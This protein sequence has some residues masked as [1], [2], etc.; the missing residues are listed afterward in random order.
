MS[1]ELSS[2][3]ETP[4]AFAEDVFFAFA[5]AAF[6]GAERF[7]FALAFGGFLDFAI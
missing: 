6:A 7:F 5:F 3:T 2:G 4:F 1:T